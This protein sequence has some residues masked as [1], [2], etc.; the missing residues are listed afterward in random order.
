MPDRWLRD[1]V[2]E[3]INS[4]TPRDHFAVVGEEEPDPA[5]PDPY[6]E[7]TYR[8]INIDGGFLDDRHREDPPRHADR[9]HQ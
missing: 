7:G 4:T 3:D 5:N 2:W 9:Q 8:V 1:G 6:P